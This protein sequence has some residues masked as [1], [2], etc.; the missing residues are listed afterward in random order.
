MLTRL[1]PGAHALC[2]CAGT[3]VHELVQAQLS[4]WIRLSAAVSTSCEKPQVL[5]CQFIGSKS[6]CWHVDP[7]TTRPQQYLYSI[8]CQITLCAA[9]NKLI[10][11]PR[12]VQGM[13]INLAVPLITAG[14]LTQSQLCRPAT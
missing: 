2:W 5:W 13:L 10:W 12:V 7:L 14:R 6:I 1:V 3:L 4:I 8:C 11:G 9:M